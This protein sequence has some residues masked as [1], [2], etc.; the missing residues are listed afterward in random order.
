MEQI[1][2]LGIPLDAVTFSQAL[3]HIHTM[4]REERQNHVVT[5]NSEM[6]V[7][8][9]SNPSFRRILQCAT[10]RLP[11]S[12]G[13]LWM[14]KCTG[15]RIPERVAGVDVVE[16]LC[17]ELEATARVFLLGG[18]EGVSQ[19]AAEFL[20]KKNPYL[21]VVG[22][23]A[24]S[25]RDDDMELIIQR[26]NAVQPHLLL[27]AFGAPEQDLWIAK[28]LHRMPSVRVAIGVGGTFDYFAG[29][30]KRAPLF[31]QRIGLE[32][33]WRLVHEPKRIRR[34]WNAVVV[35]PWLV[36]RYGKDGPIK[37]NVMDSTGSP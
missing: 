32:W 20:K 37:N 17:E 8:S 23:Y 36:M 5:P 28:Y 9:T 33:L 3:Q 24:G 14:A 6:L 15:Q 11:D 34:I 31:L 26:V 16:Y 19:S 13:L 2:L 30:Q 22:N 7:E 1:F 29:V 12:A 10:L 27:V 35:F 25:P 18:K 4:L 21:N